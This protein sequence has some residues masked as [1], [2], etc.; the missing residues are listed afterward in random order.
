MSQNDACIIGSGIRING[1]VTGEEDLVVE[2]RVEGTISL[3]NHL[4]VE[5]TGTVVADIEAVELSVRG[6]VSGNIVVSEVVSISSDA[7]VVGDVRSPRVIIEEGARFKGNI[8][9]D[10]PLPDGL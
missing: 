5:E 4:M 6:T 2:G 3:N 9:M 1:R 10:V 8:D 7:T